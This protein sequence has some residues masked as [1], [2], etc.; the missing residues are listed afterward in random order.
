[1]SKWLFRCIASLLF[2]LPLMLVTYV[3]ADA[4]DNK[5][6][7]DPQAATGEKA[8]CA[9]CHQPFQ[10]AWAMGGHGNAGVDPAFLK[11]WEFKG[12][13]AECMACHATGYDPA[14]QTWQKEGIACEVCHNPE[15][16][17]HPL[18]PMSMD[19]SANLC[20]KCHLEASLAWKSSQHA[21]EGVECSACHNPHS[22]SLKIPDV[23]SMCATCHQEM[24][25]DYAHSQHNAKGLT[26]ASC[27]QAEQYSQMGE[28]AAKIDHTFSVDLSTCNTCHKNEL[29]TGPVLK[30]EPTATP[31][32]MAAVSDVPAQKE[33][34]PVSPLGFTALSGLIGIGLGIVLAPWLEKLYMRIH[35]FSNR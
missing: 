17:V 31:D 32:A 8:D 6:T 9:S 14:T 30:P 16:A 7:N 2:A 19:R 15:T 20:A 22:T 1:M 24:V 10:D 34:Y 12:K 35:P 26:C 27:H 5:Q 33:P 3:A 29:H 28:G 23:N 4:S 18:A 13:P 21:A 11:D 25:N